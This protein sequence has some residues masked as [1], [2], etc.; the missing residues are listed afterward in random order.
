MSSRMGLNVFG[1]FFVRL[2]IQ[3][4]R[5]GLLVLFVHKMTGHG[6]GD[7]R[8]IVK[9]WPACKKSHSKWGNC[10]KSECENTHFLS[11]ANARMVS[12][13]GMAVTLIIIICLCKTYY[14]QLYIHICVLM[15]N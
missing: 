3:K 13:D 11:H 10:R 12:R 5:E 2:D 4:G 6:D 9:L 8:R 7:G 15:K 1:C 14:K